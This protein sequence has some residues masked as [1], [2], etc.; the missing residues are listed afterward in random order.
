MEGQR[1]D[2]ERGSVLH[3]RRNAIVFLTLYLQLLGMSDGAASALMALF[4]GGRYLLCTLIRFFRT[5][6]TQCACRF[7]SPKVPL[8][9][10]AAVQLTCRQHAELAQRKLAPAPKWVNRI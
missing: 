3:L 2:R 8:S 7:R 5:F 9:C 4:L 1:S 6:I 10:S